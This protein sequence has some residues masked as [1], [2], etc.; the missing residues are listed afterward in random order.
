M[1]A[2]RQCVCMTL[3]VMYCG[4]QAKVQKMGWPLLDFCLVGE[5]I[6]RDLRF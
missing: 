1:H 5:D 2:H 4:F 3:Y 6:F